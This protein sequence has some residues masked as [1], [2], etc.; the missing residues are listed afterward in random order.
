M[1]SVPRLATKLQ[2]LTVRLSEL[3]A[4]EFELTFEPGEAERKLIADRVGLAGLNAYSGRFRVAPWF[5]GVQIH[6]VWLAEIVQVCGVSLDRFE[7]PL[8]C[9]F[10]VR[11]APPDSLYAGPADPEVVVDP[12]A[13]DPPDRLEADQ[14]DLAGYV[15][16]HLSLELDPFPRKPG[17]VFEPPDNGGV[18]SPFAALQALKPRS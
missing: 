17:A 13:E 12:L 2:D 5:D 1:A 15:L 3:G 11:L 8:N 14:V 16:E 4:G 7:T 9:S 18:I 6:G 10:R